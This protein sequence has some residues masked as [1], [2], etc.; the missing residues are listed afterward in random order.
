MKYHKNYYA[1][2]SYKRE[3]KKEAK[4]LQH[5]LEYYRLPNQLCQGESGAARV[6]AA[7]VPLNDKTGSG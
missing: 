7:Y 1:F 4:R 6:C 5:D 2:I 3:D